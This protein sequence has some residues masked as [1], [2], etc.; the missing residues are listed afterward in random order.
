MPGLK[1]NFKK[2]LEALYQ[3][4]QWA[5]IVQAE[6]RRLPPLWAQAISLHYFGGLSY[7]E[8]AEAM[9]LPRA[10]VATYISRGKKQLARQIVA[11]TGKE[12]IYF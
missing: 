6:L 4:Q 9:K 5:A 10:T 8:A 11:R 2:I 12:E 3:S 1:E 7:E